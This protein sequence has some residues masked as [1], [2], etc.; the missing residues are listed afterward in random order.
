MRLILGKVQSGLS[1]P[2]GMREGHFVVVATLGW[3]PKRFTVELDFLNNPE[4]LRLLKQAED[5]FGFSH[6]GALA[7][8]CQPDELQSILG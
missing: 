3:E 8:P 1:F 2:K 6:D 5:E 4:F 7:I